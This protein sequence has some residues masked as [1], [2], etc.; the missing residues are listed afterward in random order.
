ME[1]G[2]ALANIIRILGDVTYVPF[3]A[4]GVIV[5]TNLLKF[6]F[7]KTGIKIS[8]ALVALAV[9][10]L[11]WVVYTYAVRG[12]FETQFA[13]VWKSLIGVLEAVLPLV[14]TLSAGHWGYEKAR[15]AGNPILG[16]SGGK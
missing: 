11:V 4:A 6:V 16:Y 10:V 7:D 5:L 1:Y 9:Q 13:D 3:L 15:A 12:G 8:P 14:L 2:E